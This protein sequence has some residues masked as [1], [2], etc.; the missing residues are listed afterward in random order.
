MVA[1][2]PDSGRGPTRTSLDGD[3]VIV[4]AVPFN[5]LHVMVIVWN[6]AACAEDI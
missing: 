3:C 6:N 4:V 2:F 5:A 1:R